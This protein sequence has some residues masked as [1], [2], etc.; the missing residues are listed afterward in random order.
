MK[1]IWIGLMAL[2][3]AACASTS[4]QER[5]DSNLPQYDEVGAAV[6]PDVIA[7]VQSP[8]FEYDFNRPSFPERI[9]SLSPGE[10]VIQKGIEQLASAGGGTL[11]LTEGDYLSGR[12]E[13]KSNINL[14]LQEGAVIT[15]KS[16]IADFLPVVYTRN[17]GIE[18]YS[19][20]ACIYA[21]D[22][23]NIAITG[24]GKLV[25]PG[26]GSVREQ[27]MTHDVIEN[28]VSSDIPIEQRIYDGKTTDFIFPPAMIAP[29]NCKQVFIEG[30]TL[31][32]SAFWNVVP[33]FCEDV[34]IR[35][36]Q[37]YSKGIPRGDGIDIE[38]SKNVLVE[39][40]SLYTGDDCIAIKAGR[41]YDG[42][43]AGKP[44][45]NIVVRY[46]LA[47]EG[48]GGIT[49]GS[50]TAGMIKNLYVHDCAFDGTD[51]GIR[52]KT[53]RPRGGGGHDIAF[54]NIRMNVIHSALRWD[55][56]GSAT[57]VGQQA[58]R[59][60][61]VEVNALTPAF[62]DVNIN[63]ILIESATHCI[64]VEGIPESRLK[65]V[66]ISNLYAKGK[67]YLA[68]KDAE[69]FVVKNSEVLCEECAIDSVHV[70][71]LKQ[72]HVQVTRR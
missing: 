10:D 55:M 48:H 60:F 35:G 41:G 46:C 39:Y 15:F 29:I 23:V 44:S 50:E 71:G 47:G 27:T 31:E 64:N 37:V 14:H 5:L 45:E 52:F 69:H 53:R 2:L 9:D 8:Y 38:S 20:G 32:R 67:H 18:L 59:D 6:M 17:E 16:E 34:I 62:S 58:S 57:H 66:E 30:L 40:C 11:V 70:A 7:P 26:E 1:T 54:E 25:G 61:A 43:R 65:N 12:I 28:I 33:T 22:A 3:C 42:L 4:L 13:L 36:V 56:L 19:L 21:N 24:K 63:N 49:L 72:E 68:I 51:V